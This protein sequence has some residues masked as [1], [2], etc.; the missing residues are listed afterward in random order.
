MESVLWALDLI[1]VLVLCRWALAQD[2]RSSEKS[3]KRPR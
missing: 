1:A 3:K 2:R